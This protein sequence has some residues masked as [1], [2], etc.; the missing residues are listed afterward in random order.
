M[1]RWRSS[2]RLRIAVRAGLDGGTGLSAS[3]P[4]T[5][6]SSRVHREIVFLSL[7]GRPLPLERKRY[8]LTLRPA[9]VRSPAARTPPA[10][11]AWRRTY[12]LIAFL[13]SAPMRRSRARCR[14]RRRFVTRKSRL[15][16]WCSPS[17]CSMSGIG[18][19]P[20]HSSARSSSACSPKHSARSRTTRIS[21]TAPASFSF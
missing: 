17:P 7:D 12:N 6:A 11:S 1:A 14:A 10:L 9:L 3:P 15:Q 4:R 21:L 8:A 18:P 5:S 19:P 13:I 2:H 20:V 16:W